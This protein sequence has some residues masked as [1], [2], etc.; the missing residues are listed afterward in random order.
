MPTTKKQRSDRLKRQLAER[1]RQDMSTA[2]SSGMGP[3]TF[4]NELARAHGWTD[5]EIYRFWNRVVPFMRRASDRVKRRHPELYKLVHGT[6]MFT[7]KLPHE[8]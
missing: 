2:S 1:D 5:A 7:G 6:V 3:L 4:D 8:S